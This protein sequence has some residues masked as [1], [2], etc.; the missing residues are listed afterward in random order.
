MLSAW[1][2]PVVWR[3]QGK[4]PASS[5]DW[6]LALHCMSAWQTA[7]RLRGWRK[8]KAT[9]RLRYAVSLLTTVWQAVTC[10]FLLMLPCP[11]VCM[12]AL[13]THLSISS[14]LQLIF[15]VVNCFFL[16]SLRFLLNHLP[17]VIRCKILSV[18]FNS[19]ILSTHCWMKGS[20]LK[21]LPHNYTS[22][23]KRCR[24]YTETQ[25]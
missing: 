21:G 2:Q 23:V 19:N 20:I 18:R 22:R 6:S 5:S 12:S 17:Q 11:H 4:W 1:Q 16:S 8:V 10:W 7:S 15:F 9:G 25:W 24:L 3:G 14:V 13:R